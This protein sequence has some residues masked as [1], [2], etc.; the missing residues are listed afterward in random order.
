MHI[1]EILNSVR[2]TGT[3]TFTAE[4][5]EDWVQGR[6]LFGGILTMLAVHGMRQLVSDLPPLVSAQTMF[7]APVPPG[8]VRF[9]AA[10]LRSGRSAMQMEA[11]FLVGQQVA[12][13]II[14]VFGAPRASSVAIE[15]SDDAAP[16]RSVEESTEFPISSFMPIFTKHYE[17]RLAEGGLPC[18]GSSIIG[19]KT[20]V[21]PRDTG[22]L[23]EAHIVA[24][25][26]VIPPPIL[27]LVDKPTPLSSITWTLEFVR[28]L[29]PIPSTDWWCLHAY[30][31]AARD[32]YSNQDVR[33]HGP[34]GKLVALSR[35]TVALFG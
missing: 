15:P 12:C 22:T 18:S 20:Y 8:I 30:I 32:G 13:V 34:D 7:I 17:F 35:Q 33:L 26:D 4:V 19:T 28:H 29:P 23:G 27:S 24:L 2:M 6:T 1:D 31:V 16:A 11:R 21:R 25:G 9:E 3:S 5:G 14:A 10:L